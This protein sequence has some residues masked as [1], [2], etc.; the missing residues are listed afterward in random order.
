MK[1]R[2]IGATV[3][4]DFCPSCHKRLE[5]IYDNGYT[6]WRCS[7]CKYERSDGA[8]YNPWKIFKIKRR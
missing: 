6:I 3:R 1:K 4:K 5:C 8:E 7:R 2:Q